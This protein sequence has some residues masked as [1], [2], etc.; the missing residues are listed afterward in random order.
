[1]LVLRLVKRCN[2][3]LKLRPGKEYDSPIA[4]DWRDSF[5]D[6]SHEKMLSRTYKWSSVGQ[7][8]DSTCGYQK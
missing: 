5:T 7:I 2:L 6:F 4:F 1:M 8:I 3:L